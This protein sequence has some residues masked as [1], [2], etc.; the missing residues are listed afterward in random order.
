[1]RDGFTPSL[2]D[3][4]DYVRRVSRNTLRKILDYHT[5]AR[6]LFDERLGKSRLNK[7]RLKQVI[8]HHLSS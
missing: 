5:E 4:V 1:M 3:V 7:H 2:L 8:S 6:L